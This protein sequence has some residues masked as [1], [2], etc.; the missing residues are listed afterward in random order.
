MSLL[1]CSSCV[2]EEDGLDHEF[3]AELPSFLFV[4]TKV[5]SA[6]TKLQK[7]HCGR[8]DRRCCYLQRSQTAVG[9]EQHSGTEEATYRTWG[10][11]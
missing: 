3:L 10:A 1:K 5:A 2:A 6:H 7:W 4:I 9:M 8:L 11:L